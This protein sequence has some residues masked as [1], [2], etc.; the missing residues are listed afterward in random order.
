MKRSIFLYINFM[1]FMKNEIYLMSLAVLTV[2]KTGSLAKFY[3]LA[4]ASS[5]DELLKAQSISKDVACSQH[6]LAALYFSQNIN[7]VNS[8]LYITFMPKKS[9]I[10]CAIAKKVQS[11]I[12]L[13]K[14]STKSN[15]INSICQ[16]F[17]HNFGRIV[18]LFSG[19]TK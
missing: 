1:N 5:H 11:I 8:K 2:W 3:G 15:K 16:R 4:L 6:S 17:P 19:Y 13:S 9:F 12:Y 14:N 18:D 7:F 10:E